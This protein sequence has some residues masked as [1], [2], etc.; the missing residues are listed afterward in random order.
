[1]GCQLKSSIEMK[2]AVRS[3]RLWG[4]H[5]RWHGCVPTKK[6]KEFVVLHNLNCTTTWK[7][8][9]TCK[10]RSCYLVWSPTSSMS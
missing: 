8:A 10:S 2:V 4:S 5:R 6:K 1:M 3:Q 9:G 7:R